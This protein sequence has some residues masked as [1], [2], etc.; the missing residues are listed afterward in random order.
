MD[1]TSDRGRARGRAV[2]AG[3]GAARAEADYP[4]TWFLKAVMP[5]RKG[6]PCR[7]EFIGPVKVRVEFRDGFKTTA[8][9]SA[10]RIRAGQVSKPGG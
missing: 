7:V 4:Y 9:R 10:V 5:E 3:T 6:Q 1:A 8:H 2:S